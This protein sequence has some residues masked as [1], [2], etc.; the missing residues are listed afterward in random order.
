MSQQLPQPRTALRSRTSHMYGRTMP[1]AP[2]T[3]R[4]HA[5]AAPGDG[6]GRDGTA[7]R[8]LNARAVRLSKTSRSECRLRQSTCWRLQLTAAVA[9]MYRVVDLVQHSRCDSPCSAGCCRLPARAGRPTTHTMRTRQT[10]IGRLPVPGS[11]GS[12]RRALR[13]STPLKGSST[14][15][16]SCRVGPGAWGLPGSS[17]VRSVYGYVCCTHMFSTEDSASAPGGR[18]GSWESV[19]V[20]GRSGL[21]RGRV[22]Q[23]SGATDEWVAKDALGL[24]PLSQDGIQAGNLELLCAC[25]G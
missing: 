23:C 8:G 7:A 14:A 1:V 11:M 6:T 5:C 12:Q 21:L 22:Q 10:A 17:F 13:E 16:S 19:A 3:H 4:Q 24:A 20:P 18:T 15:A 2:Y 25:C 9:V